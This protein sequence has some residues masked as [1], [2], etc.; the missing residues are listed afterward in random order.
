MERFVFE[1][2]GKDDQVPKVRD[3]KEA[4]PGAQSNAERVRA[5]AATARG[6]VGSVE[7][8]NRRCY[9]R[10]SLGL[11]EPEKAHIYA[12][13]D[14]RTDQVRYIGK[15]HCELR[16]RMHL[17][18]SAARKGKPTKCARWIQELQQAGIA[19]KIVCL[20]TVPYGDWPE[21]EARWMDLARRSGCDILNQQGAGGGS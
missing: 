18:M 5:K 11:P 21:A 4:P 6:E 15:T 16:D 13:V 3:R 19:P 12:L 7:M 8:P 14:P 17:H 1:S 9:N 20:E 2:E 10:L